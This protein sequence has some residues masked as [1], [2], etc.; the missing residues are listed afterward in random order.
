MNQNQLSDIH[1][2]LSESLGTKKSNDKFVDYLTEA[3]LFVEKETKQ[4]FTEQQIAEIIDF[5]VRK[6]ISK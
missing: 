1:L 3:V 2:R 6:G 4:T 5:V